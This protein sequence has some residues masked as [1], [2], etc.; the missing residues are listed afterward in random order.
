MGSRHRVPR[1]LPHCC[2]PVFPQSGE[3]PGGGAPCSRLSGQDLRLSPSAAEGH[4]FQAAVRSSKM[5]IP[6]P[7]SRT[8]E[9]CSLEE[10]PGTVHLTRSPGAPCTHRW[11]KTIAMTG[12][13]TEATDEFGRHVRV[14][15]PC[16]Q[17]FSP[18]QECWSLIPYTPLG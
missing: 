9:S 11:L 3:V 7:C 18:F 12:K 14:W 13:F 4:A 2:E 10:L 5:Q 15:T 17:K 16:A 8:T 1:V 6:G